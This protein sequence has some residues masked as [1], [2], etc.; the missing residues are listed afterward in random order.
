MIEVREVKKHIED[1][2]VLDG[3]SLDIHDGENFCLLGASGEG[4]SVFLKNLIGLMRPDCGSIKIDG[5]EIVG[6]SKEKLLKVQRKFGMMFQ[7]GALF[8]SL[9][10]QENVEFG[11]KRLTDYSPQKISQLAEEYLA[12]VG[13][14]GVGDKLPENLSIGMKRRVALARAVATEPKYILYDEPT[15]GLDPITTDVICGIFTDLRKK[16]DITS[17]IVTHDIQTAEK[18]ADRVGLLYSGKI[19]AADKTERFMKSESPYVRQFVRGSREGP[20]GMKN[21]KKKNES[22]D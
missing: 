19:I 18:V 21:R 12:M 5:E 8:D 9:T 7:G 3:I 6:I 4:K 15:T 10:V 11:M 13:L 20:I 1:I 2:Q 16:L 17:V 14:A 22:R